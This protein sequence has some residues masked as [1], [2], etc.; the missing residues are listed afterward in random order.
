MVDPERVRVT[1]LELR[2]APVR[3]APRA[4]RESVTLETM[5]SADYLE[6]YR[7][8]GA[9]LRWDTRLQMPIAELDS[10]LGGGSLRI[11]LLRGAAGGAAADGGAAGPVLGFCEFDRHA[12]PEIELKHFGLVPQAQGRG[13][14]PWLLSTALCLE[15]AAGARRIWLHTDTWD[16]PA[17]LP[18]YVRA[19]FRVYDVRE[20]LAEGL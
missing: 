18:V 20:E 4:G 10:L 14:G 13:L 12:F 9:P 15:W 3:A 16:H 19:G 8:V 17:A 5:T 2:E 1:Y 6:L 11:Y 7:C